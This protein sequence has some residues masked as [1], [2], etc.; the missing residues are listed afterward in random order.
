MEGRAKFHAEFGFALRIQFT[1]VR[2][3]GSLLHLGAWPAI[4]SV[5]KRSE[6]NTFPRRC[7]RAKRLE[8]PR[9]E[10]LGTEIR[11][12]VATGQEQQDEHPRRL[13]R[14]LRYPQSRRQSS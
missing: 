2:L 9:H 10:R 12:C 1:Q 4:D 3:A 13:W 8:F 11:F 6:G 7:E 14:L 5:S